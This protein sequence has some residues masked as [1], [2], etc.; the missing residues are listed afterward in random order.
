YLKSF[1]LERTYTT[2]I[3]KTKASRYEIE[4]IEDMVPMI[5]SPTTVRYDKDALKE[6]KHQGE[7]HK[8]WMHTHASNSKLV[9]PL[10][11][12]KRTLNLRLR[13]RNRRVPSERR[14]ERPERPKVIYPPVLDI[15]YFHHFLKLLKNQNP[16]DDEPMWTDDCVVAPTPGP[17]ITIPETA[18]EFAIKGNQF[19]GFSTESLDQIHD[20]LQKLI[21]QLEIL[22]VS[23]SQKDINLKFLRSLP[24]ERKTH[25]LIWRNKTNL[26]EQSLDD[27]FNSLKIY[28]AEVKSSS[29]AGSV[30]LQKIQE[31]MM[32]LCLREGVFHFIL[33]H[34]ML[35]SLN[36]MVG[37]V[38]TGV[39][40]QRMSLPTMLLWP[41]HLQVLLLTMR[42]QSR[43][44]YHAVPPPY[45][46]TFMPPKP[47][48]VFNNAPT[49]VETDH[50]AF[51]VKLSPT[52]PDQDL[53]FTIRPSTPIIEDWVFD[54]KDESETKAPQKFLSFVQS[55]K[56]VNSPRPSVQHVETSIPDATPK[57]KMAQHTAR[58]HA[59]RGNHKPYALMTH[60]NPQRHMVPDAVLTQ[61]KPVL[62]TTVRPVSTAVP[63]IKVMTM[64][65]S[66]HFLHTK[67][68]IVAKN[69]Q[70]LIQSLETKFDRLANK[71]FGR[72]YWS[73]P[74]NTQPIPRGS[75]AYQPP[76]ARN[77][78]VNAVF[79][80][81]AKSINPPDKP[82]DQQN[83]SEDTINFDS[84]DEDDEP[85]PQP[86]T[87]PTKSVKET[88]L[89]KPYKP[90][91]PYPQRLRKE[92]MEAQYGKFLDMI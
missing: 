37:K 90:K 27:L 92:K 69:Y 20:K 78:H 22:G 45:T 87:Q 74:S 16:M 63:K 13:R 77:E 64:A 28:E 76:Q 6:I 17:I 33:L 15:T 4:G 26:E 60:Q 40:K 32:L 55:T 68:S 48:L 36:L 85:T 52:K 47:N 88:S 84:N 59:H 70:D 91:I 35:W 29:S 18:N 49:D 1:D 10:S 62:I 3:T 8:L 56:Q 31:G 83:K 21:S 57:S 61:S 39:F 71:Q 12:P 43:N 80:R 7:G 46:G 73:L 9:E 54:S 53:S 50:P 23:L 24:S 67:P 41:S 51:I 38:M 25:A 79:T 82:D 44:G 81:S 65:V 72:P 30:G 42:Y 86:K 66:E 5:W 2:S 89:P 58:N 75:K 19:D 11:K 34:P 14:D